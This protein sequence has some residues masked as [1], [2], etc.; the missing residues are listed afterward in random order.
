MRQYE[1]L[2]PR[3]ALLMVRCHVTSRPEK[4][5]INQSTC[6]IFSII[7][8]WQGNCF[9]N[10]NAIAKATASGVNLVADRHRLSSEA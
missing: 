10:V 3:I 6:C 1:A 7:E 5:R 2:A 9:H 8:S 4:N